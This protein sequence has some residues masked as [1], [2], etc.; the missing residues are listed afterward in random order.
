MWEAVDAGGRRVAV[1]RLVVGRA[2]PDQ[3]LRFESEGELLARVGGRH[4]VIGLVERLRTPPALVLE[5]AEQ[6]SLRDA[7]HPGGY[8]SPP[9]PWPPDRVVRLG[10]DIADALDWLHGNRIVHRDVKPSNVLL[11][12]EHRGRLGDLSIAASGDPP[13][14][15]PDG[16]VEEN[17]GTLGYAAPE[18]LRDPSAAHASCDVYGLG[19]TLYEALTGRLPHPMEAHETE[20]TL[21]WRLAR[22]V[23]PVPL[24]HVG[25][26]GPPEL[27]RVIHRALAPEP[28]HRY[29]SAA[30]LR[31]AL[32]AIP[33]RA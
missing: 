10:I 7:I 3:A 31:R 9:A 27:A 21:R 16:W 24:A 15:L 1:K 29:P 20:T 13:K 33:L 22:G 18:L 32:A 4:R 2:T 23:P 30:D 11:D 25:F 8:E 28:T 14:S 6:G 5:W 12:G 19:A 26:R 17:A